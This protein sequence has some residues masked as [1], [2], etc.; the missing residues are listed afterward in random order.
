LAGWWHVNRILWLASNRQQQHRHSGTSSQGQA[1][2]QQLQNRQCRTVNQKSPELT[3][4][5]PTPVYATTILVPCFQRRLASY[6]KTDPWHSLA[7]RL[8]NGNITFFTHGGAVAS[9]KL[10]PGP[11]HCICHTGIYLVLY[12]TIFCP[13]TGHNLI[14]NK[15]L[16]ARRYL[17]QLTHNFAANHCQRHLGINN[18]LGGIS[19]YVI[20]KDNNI[21]KFT[22]LDSTKILLLLT[23]PSIV[24]RI[25]S[26]RLRDAYLL[27]RHTTLRIF[28]IQRVVCQCRINASDRI[29][30]GDDQ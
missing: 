16:K 13:A 19:E 17:L 26:N 25:G 15:K 28:S 30:G 2:H 8:R 7:P 20:T 18:I 11:L 1:D 9:A 12:S 10:G 6:T 24:D 3:I 14:L 29:Q 27:L 5:A 21:G 22:W 23:R 4:L